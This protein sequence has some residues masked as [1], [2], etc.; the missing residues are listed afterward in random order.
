MLPI[1][2][3]PKFS[4]YCACSLCSSTHTRMFFNHVSMNYVNAALSTS[5]FEVQILFPRDRV[6]LVAV[7]SIFCASC[8]YVDS[9]SGLIHYYH[10]MSHFLWV[11]HLR[12]VRCIQV[13]SK[14]SQV[15]TQLVLWIFI[16]CYY[17]VTLSP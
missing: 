7:S 2:M 17:V 5:F 13:R 12:F 4:C 9:V 16:L 8:R 3:P 1:C 14:D 11:I 10:G 6:A 15:K